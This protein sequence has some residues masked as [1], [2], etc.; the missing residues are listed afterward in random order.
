M[1]SQKSSSGSRSHVGEDALVEVIASSILVP[2]K[3]Q[4]CLVASLAVI[5]FPAFASPSK[6]IRLVRQS[7]VQGVS[8]L[9]NPISNQCR[10]EVGN[11]HGASSGLD[12][13]AGDESKSGVCSRG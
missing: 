5:N 13:M 6:T 1:S 9:A 12:S 10:L 3:T 7:T 2:E 8:R 4:S 11:F